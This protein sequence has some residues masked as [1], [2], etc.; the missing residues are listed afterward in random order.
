MTNGSEVL[1][2]KMTLA[3][4]CNHKVWDTERKPEGK[5]NRNRLDIRLCRTKRSANFNEILNSNAALNKTIFLILYV[6]KINTKIL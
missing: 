1:F 5:G 3:G 2:Y 6:H 4:G